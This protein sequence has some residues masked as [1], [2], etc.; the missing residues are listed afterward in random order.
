M[1]QSPVVFVAA[2]AGLF[3]LGFT[4]MVVVPDLFGAVIRPALIRAGAL[5]AGEPN[6]PAC[7][8]VQRACA[9]LFAQEAGYRASIGRGDDVEMLYRRAAEAGDARSAFMAGFIHE[10][11]YR[12]RVG[13]R[14]RAYMPIPEIE[15]QGEA[16]LPRGPGFA[17]ALAAI[18]AAGGTPADRHRRLAYLFYLRAAIDGF[19]PA[20]NNLGTMYQFGL[21]GVTARA[22]ME[23]WYERATVAGNPVALL[24]LVR[25]WVRELRDGSVSCERLQRFS[26]GGPLRVLRAS[27]EDREDEILDRTRFRGRQLPQELRQLALG[28]SSRQL[29]RVLEIGGVTTPAVS[30]SELASLA[31]E[32]PEDWAFDGDPDENESILPRFRQ[33]PDLSQLLASCLHSANRGH[34]SDQNKL[35][36]LRS[37]QDTMDRSWRRK[38]W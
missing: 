15:T 33:T 36:R 13:G 22:T 4:A 9:A 20:M 38:W 29:P 32:L 27:R 3:I 11:A 7:N 28:R 17:A 5:S 14:L 37:M 35:S 18:D 16:D 8:P 31:R 2:A 1:K 24:N 23:S 21:T 26:D 12:A 19:A 25:V 34:E 30:Q 10:E 6:I